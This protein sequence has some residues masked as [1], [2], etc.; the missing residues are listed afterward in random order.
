MADIGNAKYY[1][2]LFDSTPDV[3]HNDQM[4]EVK[5]YV[6]TEGDTVQVR[7]SFLGFI[8]IAG[9]TADA[10]T[11]DI[12]S[13]LEKDGLDIQLCRNQGYDNAATMSGIHG[14]VQ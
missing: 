6:H 13:N 9:K 5:R 10:V 8:P 3:S 4:S 12:L 1:G 14:G 2:I 7:E 11:K